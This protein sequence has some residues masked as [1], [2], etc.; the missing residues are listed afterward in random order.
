M[1]LD[2]FHP[3]VKRWFGARFAA[4][5]E[6]QRRGWPAIAAGKDVL[7]AAPTGT[8]KTLAAFLWCL[9]KLVRQA[10]AGALEDKTQ[11]VYVSPLKALASDVQHNLAQPLA[12]LCALAR[13]DGTSL[14]GIRIGVRTGDTP[15]YERQR[16]LK[17][18]P[19]ILITTPE[20]LFI[21][22]TARRGRELLSTVE[23]VIVDEIHAVADDKRGSHLALSLERL[24]AL[25]PKRP[26]RI[27]LSA[28]QKPIDEV[29]RFLV[30]ERPPPVVVDAGHRRELDL[31]VEVAAQGELS[32]VSSQKEWE[33]LYDRLAQLISQHKTTLIFVSTRRLVERIA[34]HLAER[35]G[36][37][38]VAPHHGSLSRQARHDAEQRLKSGALRAVVA[39]ASLE[40]GIDVGTVELV[41]QIGSPRALSVALQ[42]VGRAGHCLGLV[43]KGR[44]FPLTRD[45]LL[46]CAAVTWAIRRG[47][48][49]R[50]EI[51]RAP[52]DILAQQIVAAC[53]AEDW[54]VE[55]LF[56]LVRRAY[57]YRDLPRADFDAVV[58]MLEV[59]IEC[60]QGRA[61]AQLHYD[62]VNGRLRGRR[63]ARLAA[64][65]SGG[66]IPDVADYSVVAEPTGMVVGSVDEDFAVE[67]MA[68]DVFLLGN[69]SWR[70]LGVEAG[71]VR[72]EDAQGQAPTIPF[73][74]GEAPG[75]TAELSLALSELR[76]TIARAADEGG[77]SQ[78]Q[79]W[80][81]EEAGLCQAGAEQA[82]AY[83]LAARAALSVLPSQRTVVAERFFD[84][85]GGMQLVLHAPFGARINRAF[86]LALRKRF[87]RSFNFELQAAATD[88][89]IVLSLGEQHS[90]PLELTFGL[91]RAQSARAVLVQALLAAPMFKARWRWNASR[92]LVLLRRV[93]ARRIPPP[94]LRMRAE[95]LMAAVFPAQAACAENIA[96]EI[97]PPDHPLVGQTIADCLTEAMDFE[98]LHRVLTDI[99]AGN[100]ACVARETVEPS[101]LSHEILNAN[102]YA[103]LDDAPLEERRARAVSLRR[104]LPSTAADIGALDPEVIAEV[105]AEA[106]PD[107][108]SADELHEALVWL[109][110]LEE[111]QAGTLSAWMDELCAHRRATRLVL[112][113]RV[114]WV[115]AERLGAVGR[116]FPHA[117]ASP[118]VPPFEDRTSED[119]VLSLVRAR[120]QLCGPTTAQGLARVLG[121]PVPD[122][123]GALVGLEA[124]GCVLRGRF[125]D[126]APLGQVEWTDRLLLQRIHR[127]T[128][129]RLR[130]EIEPV[131][132]SEFLRFLVRWQHAAP[133]ARLH[134]KAGLRTVLQELQ[135]FE[136]AASAWEKSVLPVR[137]AKYDPSWLDALC[138]SG[139]IVWGRLSAPASAPGPTRRTRGLTRIAPLGIVLRQDLPW[140]LQAIDTPAVLGTLSHSAREVHELLVRRGA[141]FLPD[142][143]A[144]TRRLRTEVEGG[145]GELVASGLVTA[146]GFG[147][148]RSL[149]GGKMKQTSPFAHQVMGRFSPLR[150]VDAELPTDPPTDPVERAA[151]QLLRRWGVVCRDLLARERLPPWRALTLCFRRMEAKGEIRGGRFLA[152]RV[153][154]HFALPE[155]V[156]AMRQ[157]KR[158][159]PSGERVAVSPADPLNL[160]GILTPGPRLPATAQASLVYQD[161]VP[162]V[163]ERARSL[164]TS[165]S[166]RQGL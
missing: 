80:L 68:G 27:G 156:E 22:L 123:D 48:L 62:R 148:L 106:W 3:L 127:R 153:G 33:D 81:I 128:L 10:A 58:A 102:P 52:L 65:T 98:G 20:S 131:E 70:V 164:H 35:L 93:G 32:A 11:V 126:E 137:M 86:G 31:A 69:T 135:G 66:A 17:L 136:L 21:L 18:P 143:V 29:A 117:R 119:P 46:E 116:L 107:V 147:A 15:A 99:E 19:H 108:R 96:G 90:F 145:L 149:L 140:L 103:F 144:G 44:L 16:M 92:A 56:Q 25:C 63:G 76:E 79:R 157:V 13:A 84:E 37:D 125:T 30:G 142:L 9:D 78:A 71:R 114:I 36:K 150:A 111:G 47:E 134:G 41:C 89:G 105:R 83:V 101:P 77:A 14:E 158:S 120:M 151:R 26:V 8:G 121:L 91:L 72:V 82:V 97:V 130:R 51:P 94:I 54:E 28:T 88:N 161:G 59:G 74:R 64:I 115:A 166:A 163:I 113:G 24:E 141:C 138:F 165:R 122:I 6:P 75:R 139:E 45:D 133:Q 85:A 112:Q 12:E 162:M 39:S 155:A 7:I 159:A 87:C 67:S 55:A 5:T 42:R 1:R 104:S 73:W 152:G 38:A 50:L 49:D 2:P 109:G 4:P 129:A 34:H 43:P 110:L 40:L 60:R 57:S 23:T 154:E 146:D 132:T 53:A 160:V 61:T 95:D 118:A 100:I 124:Q